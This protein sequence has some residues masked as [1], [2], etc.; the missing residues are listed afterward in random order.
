MSSH[1]TERTAG[2]PAARACILSFL[3]MLSPLWAHALPDDRDQPIHIAADKALRDEK[4]GITVYTGNVRMSQGSME[5]EADSLV[6]YHISENADKIVAKGKPAK[7]RQQPEPDKALVHAEAEVITYLKNEEIVHLEIAAR[8]EQDGDIVTGD[9]IDYYIARQ[10]ITARSDQSLE[11]N[12]VEVVIQPGAQ[13]APRSSAAAAD[14]NEP[15]ADSAV[16]SARV[17][18]PATQAEAEAEADKQDNGASGA[19]DRE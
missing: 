13:A 4:Q 18:P 8:V 7:M 19:T 17:L 14:P 12:K 3:L 1:S 15:A 9:S 10:L 2:H 5:L 16:S 6:I 11:G